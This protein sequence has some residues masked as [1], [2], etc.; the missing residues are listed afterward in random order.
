[1]SHLVDVKKLHLKQIDVNNTFLHGNLNEEV[2]VQ[3]PPRY[4]KD[5]NM[6]CKLNRYLYD[7]EQVSKQ[8][9]SWLSYFL[10]TH[11]FNQAIYNHSLFIKY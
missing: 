4:N 10:Q 8:W 11:D 1:V 7:I 5:L 3:L 2:Y 9:Y 6:V